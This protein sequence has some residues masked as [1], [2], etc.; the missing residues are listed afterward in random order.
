MADISRLEPLVAKLLRLDEP[1]KLR[2]L[3][4]RL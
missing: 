2:A 1:D 3:V 4:A